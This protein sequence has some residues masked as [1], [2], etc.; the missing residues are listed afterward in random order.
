[1]TG[2]DVVELDELWSFV[3]RK[4]NKRWVWVALCRRTRQ[5]VAYVIG[6]R[7]AATCRQLWQR[8]PP[9]YRHC[10]TFSD[11]WKAYAAVFEDETHQSVGKESGQ[12]SHIERWFCVNTKVLTYGFPQENT[13]SLASTLGSLRP[14]DPVFFKN[15]PLS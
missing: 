7:S 2:G 12:T 10:H 11:F 4:T 8:I 6:D 13:N 14:Q 9:T 5:V 1:L 15:G 3:K